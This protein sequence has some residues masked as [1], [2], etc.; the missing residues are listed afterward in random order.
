MDGYDMILSFE[1]T[2]G[3][4]YY[5]HN[6]EPTWYLFAFIS[7]EIFTDCHYILT[8]IHSDTK[9]VNTQKTNKTIKQ[10]NKQ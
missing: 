7:T 9:T 5:R 2:L 3:D 4:T 6:K 8:S 10:T 1:I